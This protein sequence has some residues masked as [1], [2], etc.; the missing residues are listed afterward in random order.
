MKIEKNK[1]GWAREVIVFCVF[2]EICIETVMEAWRGRC[3]F[4]ASE[5]A[6]L[7]PKKVWLG[8]KLLM[9]ASQKV[10]YS[11]AVLFLV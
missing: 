5:L 4:K 1:N 7:A 8:F 3:G 9:V 10:C 11:L 6:T 2:V